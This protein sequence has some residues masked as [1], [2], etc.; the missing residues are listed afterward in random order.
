[1]IISLLTQ[2][3][4]YRV[5]RRQS[6]AAVSLHFLP[7]FI[8]SARIWRY[9]PCGGRV[10]TLVRNLLFAEQS[11]EDE[12][13]DHN[14]NQ[15]TNIWE[16]CTSIIAPKTYRVWGALETSVSPDPTSATFLFSCLR[17]RSVS[18]SP[19]RFTLFAREG[20]CLPLSHPP[21]LPPSL[22]SLSFSLMH[23]HTC[24]HVHRQTYTHY[25]QK[26]KD[27]VHTYVNLLTSLSLP[28]SRW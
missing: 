14:H 21:T 17:L 10:L 12:G 23:M 22:L 8:H 13:D 5:S 18:L 15:A 25:T 11:P 20:R 19:G 27:I 2:L 24:A 16:L 26:H 3:T 9:R 4:T 1:M 28:P 7:F 6:A